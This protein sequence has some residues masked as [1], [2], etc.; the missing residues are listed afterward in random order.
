MTITIETAADYD[1][2][3]KQVFDFLW[4]EVEPLASEMERTSSF[5][6]ETLFPKFRE[7][8]LFGAVI[9]KQYGGI[10]LSCVRY[11]PLLAEF[12]KVSGVV[13]V[14]LHVHN[15]SARALVA[16]GTEEQKQRWLPAIARG[17]ESLTFAIT[18]PNTGSGMDVGTHA[19]RE[20]DHWIV[21]G[22]KHY[23]TNGD[24]A[25]G[26]LICARTGERGD[27]RGL[28]ALIVPTGAPGFTIE[29]MPEMMGN[30]G[31]PHSILRFKDTPVPVDSICGTEGDG[32]DVFLGELEPSRVFVAASSL[33]TAERALEISLDFSQKRVTFGKTI[34]ARPSVQSEL[35]EMARDIYAL[36]LILE[37]VAAKIDREEAC[38]TEASIAKLFGLETVMRVT[39]KAMDVV[40]GRAYFTDYPYPLERLYRESR[41]NMLEEGTP[42]IQRLVI[43]RSLM[44]KTTPLDIGTLGTPYQPDGTDPA[45]GACPPQDLSYAHSEE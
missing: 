34:A 33:G 1:A 44:G 30:N 40:G 14:L 15:T 38:A 28:S 29:A 45:L 35:A 10:D 36:K 6:Q 3:R 43:A 11:L 27:R 4:R 42:S 25:T 9:P 41:I 21:N 23:I 20:G 8:G 5:P 18:E 12:S 2:Y 22:A 32:L 24:F 39:D 26:H 16:Y 31:P 17:D 19:R 7:H 13:R 37:D